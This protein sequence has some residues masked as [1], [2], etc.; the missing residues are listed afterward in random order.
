MPTNKLWIEHTERAAWQ[1]VQAL[2][3]KL[4]EAEQRAERMAPP[5]QGWRELFEELDAARANHALSGTS[6]AELLTSALERLARA[7]AERRTLESRLA[8]EPRPAVPEPEPPRRRR[9]SEAFGSDDEDDL[10]G[11][12]ARSERRLFREIRERARELGTK[13]PRA[14]PEAE[15]SDIETRLAD[16]PALDATE[17]A[18]IAADLA[19]LA[20]HL[21]GDR[22]P[23]DD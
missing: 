15:L 8:G 7:E 14:D 22:T 6:Y 21:A 2:R 17:I 11:R 23:D 9:R 1:S 18:D 3:E 19:A 10:D 5:A 12:G 4:A 13:R 16:L 20:L